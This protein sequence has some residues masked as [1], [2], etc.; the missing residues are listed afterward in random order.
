MYDE[1]D[2]SSLSLVELLE[3]AQEF[4][5]K[6]YGSSL[7]SYAFIERALNKMPQGT[8]GGVEIAELLGKAQQVYKTIAEIQQSIDQITDT[9]SQ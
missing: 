7:S 3:K 9:L 2:W 4:A 8:K 1:P 5:K 6:A